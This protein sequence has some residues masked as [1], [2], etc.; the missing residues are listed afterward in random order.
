MQ[1]I[2]EPEIIT[3]IQKV[4]NDVLIRRFTELGMNATGQWIESLEVVAKDNK[5][6]IRGQNYTEYLAKGRRPNVNQDP[7]SKAKWAVGMA[8][9]NPEFIQWLR[10]RGLTEY[11]IQIAY[12]IADKGTTWH[13]K[14]GTDLIEILTETKTLE[15]INN[16]IQQKITASI[17]KEL[18][19]QINEIL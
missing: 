2:T 10:I 1:F 18:Q 12:N 7:K 9:K 17:T 5:G 4:V 19:R 15:I 13:Q 11:G 14:G 6:I 8:K 16:E 3:I